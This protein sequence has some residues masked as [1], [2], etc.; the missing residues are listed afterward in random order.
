VQCDQL[1]CSSHPLCHKIGTVYSLIDR[2]FLLSHP[3]FHQKNIEFAIKLLLD[4]GYPLDFTFDKINNRLKS[5]INNKKR[6][7]A[8]T[9][10]DDKNDNSDSTDKKILVLPYINNMSELIASTINKSNYITGYRVLNNLGEFIKVHK[11]KNKLLSTNN[12]VY[13]IYCKDCSASYVGQTKRQLK[14]RIK[15]HSNNYK[16]TPVKHSVITEHVLKHSHS[17]DWE[18]VEIL[19]TEPNF[20]KRSVS[21]ML[22]IKEQLNGINSQKDTELLDDAYHDILDILS[23]IQKHTS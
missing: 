3:K 9:N 14:T 10:H 21:E 18:K 17:F 1:V 7:L 5:L 19:D 4:N 23:K 22:H 15:E 20:F 8:S 13:K 12:V 16:L 2:A 6:Q 11:D